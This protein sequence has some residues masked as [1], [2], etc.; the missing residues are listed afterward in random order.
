M[1]F[2]TDKH[3]LGLY[4]LNQTSTI[5]LRTAHSGGRNQVDRVSAVS[6]YS[7]NYE[8]GSL[9]TLSNVDNLIPQKI[10]IKQKCRVCQ[11]NPYTFLVRSP[12]E[13]SQNVWEM[14][15][16]QTAG[17]KLKH[18]ETRNL[19]RLINS[20]SRQKNFSIS[21]LEKKMRQPLEGSYIH[22]FCVA[23]AAMK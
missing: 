9:P 1:F 16:Y 8:S 3:L 21:I 15:V 13:G 6:Y 22:F 23:T 2:E 12:K 18:E 10:S 17:C 19:W 7:L 5:S 11:P 20:V 4:K 14:P